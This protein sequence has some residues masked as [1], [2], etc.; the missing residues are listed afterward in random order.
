[1]DKVAMGQVFLHLWF[2]P[3]NVIPPWL[4]IL[5]HPIPDSEFSLL[6]KIWTKITSK[7][8]VTVT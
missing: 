7:K 1:M 6:N 2:S 5:T 4:S 3:V 8:F